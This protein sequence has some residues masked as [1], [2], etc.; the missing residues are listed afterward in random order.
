MNYYPTHI[1]KDIVEHGRTIIAIKDDD[2]PDRLAWSYT[3]GN[4]ESDNPTP[5][6]LC[7]FPHQ[8]TISWTLNQLSESLR[9]EEIKPLAPGEVVEI[10]G[11]LGEFKQF[12]LRLISLLESEQEHCWEH[13]TCQL[14]PTAPVIQVEIPDT[15]GYYSHEAGSPAGH[16]E[17]T[18]PTRLAI[19]KEPDR[20]IFDLWGALPNPVNIDALR[21][22]LRYYNSVFSAPLEGHEPHTPATLEFLHYL[23]EHEFD[24]A[25]TDYGYEDEAEETQAH[26]DACIWVIQ[27][28]TN[29]KEAIAAVTA[30]DDGISPFGNFQ[31]I[32]RFWYGIKPTP[33][34]LEGE[35]ADLF[36]RDNFKVDYDTAEEWLADLN[37]EVVRHALSQA[38]K[39]SLDEET[40]NRHRIH[41]KMFCSKQL[42]TEEAE[43]MFASI[44]EE[45]AAEKPKRITVAWLKN[46]VK[47]LFAK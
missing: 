25:A 17:G 4:S 7:F 37:W 9:N 1:Q 13:F 33:S 11:V 22:N 31:S 28:L 16:I 38:Y 21:D 26:H 6:L 32:E 27:K 29:H 20:R 2:N 42:S 34:D 23:A 47:S 39:D 44:E 15:A 3:I 43:F 36:Q 10:Y 35:F 40:T 19:T 8:D 18:T 5:E 41:H 24:K 14:N 12:P 46:K 45:K 30:E